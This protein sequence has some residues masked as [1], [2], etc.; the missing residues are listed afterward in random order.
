MRRFHLDESKEA[1]YNNGRFYICGGEAD[2]SLDDAFRI[3]R[4][5]QAAIPGFEVLLDA[6]RPAVRALEEA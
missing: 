6:A 4:Y 3:D 2:E 1:T 5:T